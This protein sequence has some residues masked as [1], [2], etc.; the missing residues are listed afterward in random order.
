MLQS[1]VIILEAQKSARIPDFVG[2]ELRGWLLKQIRIL[3]VERGGLLHAGSFERPYTISTLMQADHPATHLE[4]GSHYWFRITTFDADTSALFVGVLTQQQSVFLDYVPLQI[5]QIASSPEEHAF[6]VQLPGEALLQENWDASQQEKKTFTLIFN[7]PTS[8]GNAKS[9]FPMPVPH[10]MFYSY[11]RRWETYAQQRM[12][13]GA[14]LFAATSM[15]VQ[16]AQIGTAKLTFREGRKNKETYAMGFV[17]EVTFAFLPEADVMPKFRADLAALQAK[18]L[19]LARF[20]FFCGTGRKT[21]WG[22][23]QTVYVE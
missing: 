11:Q 14:G 16:Q 21:G 10:L 13:F 17:G 18:I 15:V 2:Y 9:D 7:S 22:M 20:S 23:G 5:V 3:D 12:G 1:L 6:A 4:K 19:L 8:F